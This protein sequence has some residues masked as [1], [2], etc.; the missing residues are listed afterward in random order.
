MLREQYWVHWDFLYCSRV[1]LWPIMVEWE[2]LKAVESY[3][4]LVILIARTHVRFQ[5]S[6]YK[7]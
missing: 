7:E 2:S 3:I 5:I 4:V 1:L 6:Y